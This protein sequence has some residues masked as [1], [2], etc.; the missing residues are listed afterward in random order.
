VND[1]RHQN[2]ATFYVNAP[3]GDFHLRSGAIP[4]NRGN[5]RAYPAADRDG[6]NRLVGSAPDAGAY[7]F[8]GRS[9]TTGILA[10]GD[11]GSGAKPLRGLGAAMRAF[12]K[13]NPASL[14]VALGNN[15]YTRGRGFDASWGSTFARLRATGIR[16]AGAL[17]ERDV[18]VRRGRY[19]FRALQMPGA[20]YTRRVGQVQVIVLDATSVSAAQTRWL[21]RAL[22]RTSSLFRVVVLHDPPF[23]C[24]GSLGNAAVRKSWVPLIERYGVRLVL[25]GGEH[26]YQR[27]EAARTT[28]VV[29][30]GAG[31]APLSQLRSCPASY[32][33]RSAARASRGF[34]Y[35]T[36]DAGGVL[37]RAVDNSGKTIDRFRLPD[38]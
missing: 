27:F 24:G 12:E 17:G 20:Y 16:F 22:S 2:Q 18:A 31:S 10:I 25:S 5:P 35:F 3:K 38:A 15:D 32:P 9:A 36:V 14:A 13:Q 34:L 4:I 23:A 29:D 28:Y 6:R 19:Q 37:L 1:S 26:N 33:P 30:G 21:K 7:E 8:R 11:F